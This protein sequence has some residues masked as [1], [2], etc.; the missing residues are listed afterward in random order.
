MSRVAVP[1]NEF[2]PHRI[3]LARPVGTL[4]RER[5]R[6]SKGNYIRDK[7]EAHPKTA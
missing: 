2:A 4:A 5:E 6:L 7:P 3:G 1:L